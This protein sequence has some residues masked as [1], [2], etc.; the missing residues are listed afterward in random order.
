M[1]LSPLQ[2]LPFAGDPPSGVL[3]R[4]TGEPELEVTTVAAHRPTDFYT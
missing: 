1:N 4:G 2:L 3:D